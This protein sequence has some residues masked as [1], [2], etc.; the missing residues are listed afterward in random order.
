MEAEKH[1]VELIGR[2]EFLPR[3]PG[4]QP[5]GAAAIKLDQPIAQQVNFNAADLHFSG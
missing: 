4:H 5:K 2:Q 1:A 3:N